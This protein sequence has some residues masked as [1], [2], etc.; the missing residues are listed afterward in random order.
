MTRAPALVLAGVGNIRE[1]SR[2]K[3]QSSSLDIVPSN[4]RC[5]CGKCESSSSMPI[6]SQ[7][8]LRRQT[9]EKLPDNVSFTWGVWRNVT[10]VFA[11]AVTRVQLWRLSDKMQYLLGKKVLRTTGIANFFRTTQSYN[12]S[13]SQSASHLRKKIAKCDYDSF[14]AMAVGDW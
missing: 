3:G 10:L 14:T 11:E 5:A 2:L 4:Q 7:W 9:K 8:Y 13:P 6:L 12:Q 1:I